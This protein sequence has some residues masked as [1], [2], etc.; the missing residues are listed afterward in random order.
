MRGAV[1]AILAA[2]L[3][4]AAWAG[5]VGASSS[6]A[7][8]KLNK[9]IDR[10]QRRLQEMGR[11]EAQVLEH[12]QSLRKQLDAEKQAVAA[13]DHRLAALRPQVATTR[14]W[15]QAADLILAARRRWFARRARAYY[16]F[17]APGA[18]GFVAGARTPEEG[19]L[20]YLYLRF[21]ISHDKQIMAAWQRERLYRR[22]LNQRLAHLQE[23]IGRTIAVQRRR[24]QRTLALS[25]RRYLLLRQLRRKRADASELVADLS[26]ARLRLRRALARGTVSPGPPAAPPPPAHQAGVKPPR[27]VP[28]TPHRRPPRPAIQKRRGRLPWPVSP[29]DL[30]SVHRLKGGVRPWRGLL[31]GT[32]PG[33]L[34]KCIYNGRVVFAGWFRGFGQMVIIGHGHRIYSVMAHLAE[35]TVT[36]GRDVTTGTV[37]GRTGGR[38]GDGVATM[39]FEIRRGYKAQDAISW[40]GRGRRQAGI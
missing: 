18:T 8:D 30:V 35:V 29:R 16:K 21:A 15:I 39:Y 32:K 38:N 37:I 10:H 5:P 22:R 25:G 20:R 4:A 17:A 19:A 12:I 9:K 23:S 11:R 33:S 14:L 34:V 2:A 7:L 40:L 13:L 31:L 36:A 24:F 1:T 26:L 3:A 27:M 6:P 28:V